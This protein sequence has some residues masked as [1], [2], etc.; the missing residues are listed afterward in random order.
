MSNKEQTIMQATAY[1]DRARI[2]GKTLE[3]REAARSGVPVHA[4]RKTV[5]RRTGISPGTLE[6]LRVG[7][8]K[9]IA[10]HVY[11]RLHAAVVADLEAE[12]GRLQHELTI[13]RQAGVDPR[14]DEMR[15]VETHL[16]RARA[17]LGK[18]A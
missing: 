4:A 13:A 17:V 18:D 7:R 8:L 5:A 2:W 10:V 14:S 3:D 9:A 15:E 11:D 1:L 16:A 12:I 6:T